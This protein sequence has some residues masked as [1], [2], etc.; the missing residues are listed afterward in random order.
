MG[1]LDG[2]RILDLSRLLPGP[3]CT[4]IL[5]D[6]GADII[7][8]E[9]PQIGDY[10]RSVPPFIGET[11]ALFLMLNRN[12]R[13]ITL[14]LK[15]SEAREVIHKLAKRS[16]VFVES[17]Q[18]GVAERLGVGYQAI[19]LTNE[20]IIYC[21]ISGYGQTGPYRDLV[22]HD[23]TYTSYSGAIGATGVEEGPPVIPAIQIADIQGGIYATV[24]ILAAL[25]RRESTGKGDFIDISLTDAAVASMILPVSFHL[26][27]LPTGRGK[28]A[29]SGAVPF[30][31]VYKTADGR[32]IAIAPLEA[33]FWIELCETLGLEKYEDKQ[34]ATDE[35]GPMRNDLARILVQ[36][37]RDEWVKILGQRSIPCAPVYDVDETLNDPHVRSRDLIFQLDT[38]P[39]GELTQLATPIRMLQSPRS[40]RS[41][42]PELGEHTSQI[43]QDLGYNASH[44]ERLREI[45][46]I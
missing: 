21:S 40:V 41:P 11:G 3:L 27:G 16:D 23:L 33:K 7:K 36:R 34:Y 6:L 28:L 1:A 4:M 37:S 46:A 2:V 18:P 43:L 25:Y 13:S 26:A 45:G 15:K 20:R 24:A 5:G 22:G 9:Q 35:M 17:F 39:Y 32:F 30:Y 44:L 8:V 42:P 38:E 29:L 10:A 14:N 12:K 19:K 31:N